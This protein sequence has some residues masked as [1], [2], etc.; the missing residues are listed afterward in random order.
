MQVLMDRRL[1]SGP[2]AKGKIFTS[3]TLIISLSF[4]AKRTRLPLRDGATRFC[5]FYD[6]ME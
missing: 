1:R 6:R 4:I 2:F 3:I 5:L